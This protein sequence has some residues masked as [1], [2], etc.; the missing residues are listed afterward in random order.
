MNSLVKEARSY[1]PNYSKN[2]PSNDE[3]ELALGWLRSEYGISAINLACGRQK[4]SAAVY[5]DLA[6]GL[7]QAFM[8]GKIKIT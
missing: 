8:D 1:R 6:R 3:I 2:R 5:V 4:N 7:R